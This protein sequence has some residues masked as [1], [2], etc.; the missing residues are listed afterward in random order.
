[1]SGTAS[2]T[3]KGAP[4]FKFRVIDVQCVAT[5][6]GGAADTV[7]VKNGSDAITDAIDLNDSDKVISRA[8]TIDDAFR[9]ID[10]TQSLVVATA[11]DAV[12]DV[13]IYCVRI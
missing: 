12:A 4:R 13:Y 11:S 3:V 1:V 5:A 2:Y 10:T 7:T 6:A 8:A 9:D